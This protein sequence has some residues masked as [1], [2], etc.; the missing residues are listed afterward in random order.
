MKRVDE[1][2]FGFADAENYRRRENKNT[3]NQ[4][5]IRNDALDNLCKPEISF[6]MGE[7]GTGKTAYSV[8]LSN[9]EYKNTRSSINYVRETEYQKFIALKKDKQL[10]LSDYSAI[11]KII[12]MLLLSQQIKDVEGTGFLA[13]VSAK[14]SALDKAVDDYY[15]RAFSPEIA[16][17]ISFASE[18]KFSAELVHKYFKLAG[19]DKES[20]QFSESRFQMNLL[21]V[22]RRFQDALSALKLNKN[23]LIFIDGIDVR[24]SFVP[25]HDYLECIKGLANAIWELNNDFFPKIRDSKGRL[26][27]V[28]LIR[29]DIF[30]SIGLQNQNTKLRENSVF[31]DWRTTYDAHR[32]SELFKV[33]EHMLESQQVKTREGTA[34]WDHYFPWNSSS[35]KDSYSF[36]LPTTSF[37]EFLRWSYYRPRD[38]LT[39]LNLLK[40]MQLRSDPRAPV[41][42]EKIFDGPDFQTAYSNYL[43]GEV[44]DHLSFYYSPDEYGL[45]I[46][47]F[48]FLDGK[49]KFDYEFYVAAFKLLEEHIASTSADKPAFMATAN[50]FLQFLYDLNV[51]C[52]F[53]KTDRDETL[54][55]WCF[56][57]RE[58]SNISPKVKVGLEY[59]VFYGLA[60]ALNVGKPLRKS[61]RAR[62]NGAK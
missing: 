52:Y 13:K 31:L 61:S 37:V 19:E 32:T 38:I 36:N 57:E 5:F 39:M 14:F 12:I 54:L 8:Y 29:P 30:D 15:N 10:Q 25:F 62:A 6:L 51:V 24:P 18:N 7:K 43:L 9:N 26:R 41:F 42:S 58:Y 3:L 50:D 16:Y 22:Q 46:K 34:A 27:A 1:L 48:E 59:Q 11:W 20:I 44:K 53:E 55:R 17:A 56:R 40:D 23:H 47:F 2:S 45:F 49:N 35:A 28:L 4:L 21:Y 60:K 33:T